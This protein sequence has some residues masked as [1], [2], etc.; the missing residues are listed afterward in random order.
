MPLARNART[1]LRL[2]LV[3]LAAALVSAL[4]GCDAKSPAPG[5]APRQVTVVGHGKVDGTPDTLTVSA[6]I[7]FTAP[8][9]TSA[10]NQTN[11]RQQAVID[12]LVNAGVD[13]K[14]ISTSN[15]SLQ[16]QYGSDGSTVTGYQSTNGINVKIRDIS[17]ASRILALIVSTGGDATR[18]NSVDFSIND[19]SQLVR[20]ARE[21]AFN[22]ARDR[23]EQFAGLSGLK[24]GHV[25]S[26]SEAPGATGPMPVPMPRGPMAE[27]AA[28]P[29]LQP[30]QQAVTFDVT[31]VW[32]L[33]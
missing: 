25:L 18:I 9:V 22:D 3:V 20:D 23:A 28:A 15:V 19:D 17:V 27:M 26:I 14:D 13:S 12:A 7:T 24:L 5:S 6:A 30:G 31:V 1:P 10:M 11:Q 8:D 32:E 29:P 21:H 16:S 33:G 4:A 2:F